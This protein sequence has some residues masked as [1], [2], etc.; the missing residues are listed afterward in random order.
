MSIIKNRRDTD[1]DAPVQCD[2]CG[3][4]QAQIRSLSLS[5]CP[6]CA[7]AVGRGLLLDV[8]DTGHN[9]MKDVLAGVQNRKVEIRRRIFPTR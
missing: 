9:T 4:R 8:I 6:A 1:P 3:D 2:R 7:E 5:L